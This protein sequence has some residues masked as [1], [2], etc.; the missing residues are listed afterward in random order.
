M[1]CTYIVMPGIIIICDSLINLLLILSIDRKYLL[2]GLY[3]IVYRTDKSQKV[4]Y[5][6]KIK[7]YVKR[8]IR[9]IRQNTFL[10]VFRFTGLHLYGHTPYSPRERQQEPMFVK[11]YITSHYAICMGISGD[12]KQ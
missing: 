8:Q 1:W 10:G 11:W 9:Q 7:N 6:S 12:Q 4:Y 5:D 2:G 3:V